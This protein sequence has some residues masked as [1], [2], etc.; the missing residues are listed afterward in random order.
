MSIPHIGILIFCFTVIYAMNFCVFFLKKLY[1]TLSIFP[2]LNL[3]YFTIL[4]IVYLLFFVTEIRYTVGFCKL[5]LL[6]VGN[7]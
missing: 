6:H 3:V 4:F 5:L 7:V 2:L 1:A